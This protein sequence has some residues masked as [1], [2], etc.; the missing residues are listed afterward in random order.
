[1][2]MLASIHTYIYIY[3][4]HTISLSLSHS[5][6]KQWLE[7]IFGARAGRTGAELKVMAAI[8]AKL[9]PGPRPGLSGFGV[10]TQK[11]AA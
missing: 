9:P 2:R 3:I 1:M 5:K 10:W 4:S 6:L 7:A 11:Y 8:E